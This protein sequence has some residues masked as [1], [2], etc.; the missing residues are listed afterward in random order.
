MYFKFELHRFA[1]CCVIVFRVLATPCAH[2]GGLIVVRVWHLELGVPCFKNLASQSDFGEFK[3]LADLSYVEN[4]HPLLN[5][6]QKGVKSCTATFTYVKLVRR[7]FLP[8]LN[9][10]QRGVKSCTGA[11][12][13]VYLLIEV[14]YFYR[15]N[16][17]LHCQRR[18]SILKNF[19]K[20]IFTPFA[21]CSKG[22]FS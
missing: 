8:L 1:D 21:H 7:K 3:N 18:S 20:I 15:L 13:Y 11:F 9:I 4:F 14:E 2:C 22:V 19:V 5:K 17:Y 16:W 6:V 10:V 12:T